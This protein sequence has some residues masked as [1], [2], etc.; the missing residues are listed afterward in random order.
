MD[1]TGNKT[2]DARLDYIERK[3]EQT[4]LEVIEIKDRVKAIQ[5][6]LRKRK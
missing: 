4:L 2:L 3:L 1:T 6:M 5:G